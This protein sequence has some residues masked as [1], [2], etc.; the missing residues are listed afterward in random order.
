MVDS[1]KISQDDSVFVVKNFWK[2]L[3]ILDAIDYLHK[4]WEEVKNS[5][6]NRNWSKLLQVV[7]LADKSLVKGEKSEE[8]VQTLLKLGGE[9]FDHLDS[10][11]ISGLIQSGEKQL[12]PDDIDNLLTEN[13][14]ETTE[15]EKEWKITVIKKI[16]ISKILNFIQNFTEEATKWTWIIFQK[17]L[18][19]SKWT[20]ICFRKNSNFQNACV[21]YRRKISKS[22]ILK[23]CTEQRRDLYSVPNKNWNIS[24][25]QV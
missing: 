5:T 22:Q 18:K 11:E 23:F 10:S 4:S 19:F 6:L 9:G 2:K 20:P 21:P 16:N 15:I 7:V 1:A 3:S 17:K 25:F 12:T 8:C 13:S 14:Q 24:T